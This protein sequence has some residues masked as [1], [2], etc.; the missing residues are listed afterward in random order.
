MVKTRKSPVPRPSHLMRAFQ[1]MDEWVL[2]SAGVE[3]QRILTIGRTKWTA[4]YGVHVVPGRRRPGYQAS[5]TLWP[6]VR[7]RLASQRRSGGWNAALL[8]QGWYDRSSRELRRHGYRG[9]WQWSPWGRFGDFR[10]TLKSMSD[11]AV[12]VRN[13]DRLRQSLRFE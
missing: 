9:T 6:R 7:R 10:K 11:L 5:V 13:V 4:C 8:E 12:E 1:G 3:S 2:A